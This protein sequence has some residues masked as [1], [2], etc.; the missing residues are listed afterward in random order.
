MYGGGVAAVTSFLYDYITSRSTYHVDVIS[1]ALSSA[2]AASVR[3]CRPDSW[4]R[5]PAVTYWESGDMPYRH[6]GAIFP[7]WETRRYR[8]RRTLTRILSEYDLI[9]VVG[10]TPA[11]TL[12]VAGCGRPVCLQVATLA[13][14][15]RQ[16]VL[17]TGGWLR[18]FWRRRMTAAIARLDRHAIRSVDA[19]FVE[20]RWMEEFAR[21]HADPSCVIFAP[22]GVDTD[23]F[24]LGA[25][26]PRGHLL[27][28]ARFHDPRKNVRLLFQAYAELGRRMEAVPDLVLAGLTE[29]SQADWAYAEHSGVAKRIHM[30]KGVSRDCLRDLYRNA[31]VFVLPSD[32]EGLGI[33]ILEAMASGAPI[34]A[35][36]CGGPETIVV[37]RQN[38]YLTPVGNP[39]A[40]AQAIC[41]VLT[42]PNGSIR[43]RSLA[44]KH[45]EEHFSISS[46]AQRFLSKYD[47]LLQ[48]SHRRSG[49][50]H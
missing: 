30:M 16:S 46:T 32:E 1:L 48:H 27:S 36:R 34:V 47:E 13:E 49:R 39:D 8:P 7:E 37:D 9:Q 38:G 43:M 17:R 20:N 19:I 29:P 2:D 24:R 22:P 5:S 40:L 21:R 3:L 28:V 31:S 15:E 14:V 23:F 18:R 4:M 44:R 6:V 42:D 10:G 11:W 33:V 25:Y 12:A 26:R 35:T 41:D 45:V 50:S